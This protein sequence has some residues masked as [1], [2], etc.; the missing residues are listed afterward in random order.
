VTWTLRPQLAAFGRRSRDALLL[1]AVTGAVVG[2][3]VAGFEWVTAE[4]LLERVFELPVWLQALVPGLG[5]VLAALALRFVAGGAT[6]ATSDEYVRNFHEPDRRLDLR[7]VPGRI[8]ASVATLGSGGAL[9]FEGPSIYLG[10]AIGTGLQHRFRRLFSRVDTKLLMVAGAAA[11]VA[12]I[13]KTPATGAVFALEVPFQDDTARR[14]LLPALV[15]SASGYLAYVAFYGTSPLFPVAGSPPFGWRELVG[16]GVLGI[17]CGLGARA[18]AIGVQAAKRLE[19]ALPVVA[20]VAIGAAASAGALLVARAVF[21]ESLTIGAGYNVIDWIQEGDHA[22]WLVGTLLVLRLVAVSGALVGGG[23]GGL[24]VPLVVVGALLGQL[25]GDA[26][27]EPNDSLFPVIG[28]AAFLGA[29]YRTPLA[30]VVFV[31]E[32]TGRPGFIVPGLIATVVAQLMMGRRSV[33]AYQRT[34]RVGHLEER[35][36]LPITAAVQ[37]DVLSAPPDL[38]IDQL[39]HEHLLLTRKTTVPV[40]DGTA[41]VGVVGLDDLAGVPRDRWGEVTVA[42]VAR[43]DVPVAQPS[44]QLEDAVRAMEAAGVDLLPVAD[45]QGA[46]VGIVTASDVVRLDE[47]LRR[48]AEGGGSP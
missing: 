42:E 20:K 40:V 26:F 9:G 30:A 21:G 14:L 28:V 10:A 25:M 29:G 15:A 35:F 46:F 13:F 11:G 1:S 47:I 34:G 5:L 4:Q 6:P 7:A 36:A 44:W 31:A 39:V 18:F 2:L 3:A 41:V 12:A 17:V 16:A 48:S 24:F 33:A 23:A 22:W 19:R 32:S 37:A 38:T 45:D 8:L 43:T 27:G